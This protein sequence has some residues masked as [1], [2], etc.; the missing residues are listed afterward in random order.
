VAL[1]EVQDLRR[2]YRGRGVLVPA[3][4]GVSLSVDRGD[5]V[6]VMGPSGSGKSTLLN[7]LGCLDTPTGGRYWLD[8]VEVG[9]L[10]PDSLS[11]IRNRQLGFVFQGF[12]LLPRMSALGNVEV[13]LLYAGVPGAE[14][15]RRAA[16]RL[17]ALGLADRAHHYPSQLSGGQQQRVAI[18]RALINDPVVLLAD[19][20]T[21]ALDT[22]T[23]R[24]IMAILQHL[25]R[26]NGLTIVLITHEADIA[27]WAH[28]VVLFR[29]GRIVADEH[30]P[31]RPDVPHLMASESWQA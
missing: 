11:R 13:P 19:E 9:G 30:P 31:V 4:A 23:A 10:D 29:D 12:N 14:R 8:G 22:H 7:L 5:F 16:T 24:E 25:N 28:R 15:R 20:P 6:A 18:A 1:I 27:A 17:A 21:G 3:V 26:D 2:D